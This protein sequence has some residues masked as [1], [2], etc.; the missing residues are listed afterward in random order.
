M[1]YRLF[2]VFLFALSAETAHRLTL[3]A[4][5]LFAALPGALG[6]LR[7][8]FG[9][10]DPRLRLRALGLD[11]SSPVGLAAGLDKEA[12]VFEAFGAVGFGFV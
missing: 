4:L 5:R 8:L 11:L 1:F 7:L 12:E 6:V 9:V 10:S 3:G 2:R